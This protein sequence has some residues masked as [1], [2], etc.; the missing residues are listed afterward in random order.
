[1]TV[2]SPGLAPSFVQKAAP[3]LMKAL[4]PTSTMSNAAPSSESRPEAS[5]PENRM[6]IPM[7]EP[8]ETMWPTMCTECACS[9]AASDVARIASGDLPVIPLSV[10]AA[11]A[12][13]ANSPNATAAISAALPAACLIPRPPSTCSR[14][15]PELPEAT[16]AGLGHV[17]ATV[18]GT[19]PGRP[20][21][22][23]DAP[24]RRPLR[25]HLH[26]AAERA[27]AGVD[28][29]ADAE[30][31]RLRARARR[32]RRLQAAQLDDAADRD[33]GRGRRGGRP[34]A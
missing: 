31:R 17:R 25:G 15:M 7:C 8:P 32:R 20:V 14:G 23:P 27:P 13:A 26:R 6:S 2:G 22:W 12:P 1:V 3:P 18:P 28:P 21:G 29:P 34:Q 4:L 10:R 11:S 16:P 24:D 33:R 30:G 5:A 19:C 9:P